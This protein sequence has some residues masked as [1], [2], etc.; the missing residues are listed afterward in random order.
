MKTHILSW[1]IL[2]VLIVRKTIAT[3]SPLTPYT[4]YQ[5]S[6]ELEHNIADLWWIVDENRQEITF[7]LHI[8]T[9]R[10]IAF[11]ISP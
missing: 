11:G 8:K 4:S 2:S 3:T 1:I 9:T 6:T 5:F 7:E 10:W